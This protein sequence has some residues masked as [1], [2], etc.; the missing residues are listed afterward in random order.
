MR[1]NTVRCAGLTRF[2]LVAVLAVGAT[3]VLAAGFAS[4]RAGIGRRF[5][6]RAE[7]PMVWVGVAGKP[8]SMPVAPT[9]PAPVEA[10]I[11]AQS[12]EESAQ[13][14]AVTV[15]AAGS[16]GYAEVGWDVLAGF[17]YVPPTVDENGK[18]LTGKLDTIPADIKAMSGSR[19]CVNGYMLPIEMDG[20]AVKAFI[21]MRAPIQCCY[22][23]PP[24]PH[25]WIVVTMAE[26]NDPIHHDYHQ[27]KIS[28]TLEVGEEFQ[29][30]YV[31]SVYRMKCVR[32]E[33]AE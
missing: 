11:P 33:L 23:I 10:R 25:E 2:G 17:V 15:P 30:G 13:E 27:M 18:C 7:R 28:G 19:I 5:F 14:P 22:S 16:A 1:R 26:G 29:D 32:V 21:L 24:K 9:N 4:S 8:L 31:T 3:A 20:E 6:G 12:T